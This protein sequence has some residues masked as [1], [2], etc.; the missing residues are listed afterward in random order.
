M[1]G[2]ELRKPLLARMPE[3]RKAIEMPLGHGAFGIERYRLG[4]SL[5][6]QY[7][8]AIVLPNSLKS[9]FIFLCKDYPSSR[10]ER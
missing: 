1:D 8:M 3:V 4:K 6:E 5:R 7:D 2:I 10:L 9:A